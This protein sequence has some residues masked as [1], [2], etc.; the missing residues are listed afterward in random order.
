MVRIEP[1]PITCPN[2]GDDRTVS[3]V[4]YCGLFRT[5]FACHRTSRLRVSPN[6]NVFDNAIF[7]T[8]LPG[9]MM[10]LRPALPKLPGAGSVNAAVLNHS[11]NEGS[12]ND[13]G[14]PV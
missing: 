14:S 8:A 4:V 7:S 11:P 3:M 13:I 10:E 9:P 1:T 6:A 2:V 12:L 5:L